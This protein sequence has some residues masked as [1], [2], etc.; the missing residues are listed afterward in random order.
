MEWISPQPLL[1]LVD[2]KLCHVPE[3]SP[4]LSLFMVCVCLCQ[5]CHGVCFVFVPGL[6]WSVCF[7]FVPGWGAP[8]QEGV[9]LEGVMGRVVRLTAASPQVDTGVARLTRAA[10]WTSLSQV[11]LRCHS[12]TFVIQNA[13]SGY[14]I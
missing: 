9:P 1:T 3:M 7:V 11:C 13:Q 8:S 2:T 14:L 10:H 6:S 4:R 5:A 12:V